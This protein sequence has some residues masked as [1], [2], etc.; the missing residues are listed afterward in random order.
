MT[1]AAGKVWNS[2]IVKIAS[3]GFFSGGDDLITVSQCMETLKGSTPESQACV[4]SCPTTF[5]PWST[6][7]SGPAV[8]WCKRIG[9]KT[10]AGKSS[11]T[12][13]SHQVPFL[14]RESAQK[15]VIWSFFYIVSNVWLTWG[16][17][18]YMLHTYAH[19]YWLWL[20]RPLWSGTVAKSKPNSGTLGLLCLILEPLVLS[21][22]CFKIHCGFKEQHSQQWG[23]QAW[24]I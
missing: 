15:R 3:L 24:K 14:W 22:P 5:G 16:G 7:L 1:V 19:I 18:G 20:L 12:S 13:D 11:V 4:P 9:A 8:I 2:S 23:G 6:S 21:R 17:E 10:K